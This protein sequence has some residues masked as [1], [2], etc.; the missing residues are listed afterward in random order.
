MDEHC[1]DGDAV[2]CG[3]IQLAVLPENMQMGWMGDS[4]GKVCPDVVCQHC[5]QDFTEGMLHLALAH[6]RNMLQR[7]RLLQEVS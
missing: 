7:M 1:I 2:A 6:R 3:V 5:S 4:P